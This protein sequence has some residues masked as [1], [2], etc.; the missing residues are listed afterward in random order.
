MTIWI[1]RHGESVS[2]AGLPTN[3]PGEPELTL[4]GR[5]QAAHLAMNFDHLDMVITSRYVRS[6]RT[7][8][9]VSTIVNPKK[10]VQWSNIHE[11]VLLDSSK[12]GGTTHTERQSAVLDLINKQRKDPAYKETNAESFL[13]IVK[14]VKNF[15]YRCEKLPYDNNVLIISHGQ[16]MKALLWTM[17]YS[18]PLDYRAAESFW[19]FQD[20]FEFGN[21]QY[22]QLKV[23]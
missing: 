9:I 8:W 12:Y 20:S 23:K 7:G 18:S 1:A 22:F 17:N 5:Q 21:C 10:L 14:R 4:K 6:I 3:S 2:N 11:L 19:N 15:Y 13:D 16:L